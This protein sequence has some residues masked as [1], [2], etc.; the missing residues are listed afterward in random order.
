MGN[1]SETTASFRTKAVPVEANFFF[2]AEEEILDTSAL[3]A[4]QRQKLLAMLTEILPRNAFYRSKFSAVS[5][6]PLNDPLERL[7]FTT[8]GELER[9]QGGYPPFGTNLTYPIEQY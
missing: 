5:F 4:L 6:D 2:L 1:H 8:R 3:R 9:D 7:P